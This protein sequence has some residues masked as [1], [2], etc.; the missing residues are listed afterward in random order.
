MYEGSRA[1]HFGTASSAETAVSVNVE[2]S[3]CHRC[4]KLRQP[5][6][7]SRRITCQNYT[8]CTAMRMTLTTV[9]TDQLDPKW[10]GFE[11]YHRTA[12]Q[13]IVTVVVVDL[14]LRIAALALLLLHL[15]DVEFKLLT[16]ENVPIR[17]ATL[18]W[19]G[20]DAGIQAS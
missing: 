20:G 8:T 1:I 17:A 16:F 10:R 6:A 13:S 7:Q 19:A 4:T 3:E 9:F 18:A 15:L 12:V 14:D 5:T 11:R 2:H